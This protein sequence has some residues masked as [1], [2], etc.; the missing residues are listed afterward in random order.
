[1]TVHCQ[2]CEGTLPASN[3]ALEFCT[4]WCRQQYHTACR[5][6]GARLHR[7]GA[8]TSA[9]L[10]AENGEIASGDA[11]TGREGGSDA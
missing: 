3:R 7:E 8:I 2:Y 4:T 11:C 9:Q 6:I 1:M 5:K 10:R